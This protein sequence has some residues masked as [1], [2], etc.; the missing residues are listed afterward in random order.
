[1]DRLIQAAGALAQRGGRHHADAAGDLAGLIGKNVPEH[2]LGHNNIK[3]RGVFADLHGAVVHKHLTVF[4]LGVLGLQAVH[5]GAPQAAG[6]QHIGLVHTGQLFAAL[7]G[8]FKADAADALDLMLGV[9]HRV[10]GQLFAVLLDRLML[11][12]I[13]AADQFAHNK[14]VNALIHDG[15]FQRRG[16][17]QLGP[18]F[19]R[20]VVGVQAHAGAQ[21]QQAF[22]GAL[23]AGQSLPLGAADGTQQ[24]TVGVFALFQFGHRQRV[25][26]FI[27]GLAA[28]VGA[29]VGEGMAVL[30]CDLIQDAHRLCHDLRARTVAVDQGDVF[31]HSSVLPLV[32]IVGAGHVPPSAFPS[33]HFCRKAAGRACPAP[34]GHQSFKL[35]ISPPLAMMFWINGG[36]GAA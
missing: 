33:Q 29:G 9:G 3:L 5:D 26:E 21:P 4:D 35:F 32:A 7:H 1:M 31:L 16:I 10:D 30:G 13:D 36:N 15:L 23:F 28:H 12:E 22:F 25:A 17:G 2:I 20:A 24:D 18:D 11:A 14:E 27:D 34:T 8:C 19:S 6:V